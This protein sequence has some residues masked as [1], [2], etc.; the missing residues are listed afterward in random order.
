MAI[1]KNKIKVALASDFLTSFS[2]IPR[3]YQAKVLNFINKFRSDPMLPG[4][5]YEKIKGAKD[6]KMRSVRIDQ[7]YRGIVLKPETGNVYMLL[8]VD[9]HDEAYN[10]AKNKVYKIHPETGSIQVIE[11]EETAVEPEREA[12]VTPSL[13][14]GLFDHIHDRNLLKLGVP[15][16][17]IP[18]IRD[19]KTEDELDQAA[20]QLPQEAYEALF[21]LAAGDSLEDVLREMERVD[22]LETVDIEDYDVALDSP[23]SRR[24]FFVVEDDLE[25]A[26]ILNAPL[27]KWRVFLHPTQRKL[28]ERDWN[29]PVRVLGGAGTGKTVVAIHRARWLA[30][31]AFANENLTNE[32]T[33]SYIFKLLTKHS[34]TL[35]K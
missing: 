16:I 5:N 8:W 6:P 31:N 2:N 26:A 25:L 22:S 33:L 27:E 9:K 19:L 20:D 34:E 13:E 4:L 10:W 28:V 35:K 17:Q 24:R 29:G 32:A 15:E 18:L 12:E 23:D 3:N 30:Q 1:Q 7:S 14:K 21:F 11:I